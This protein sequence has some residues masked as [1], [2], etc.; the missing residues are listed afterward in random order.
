LVIYASHL[1]EA[2]FENGRV[3]NESVSIMMDAEDHFA[4]EGSYSLQSSHVSI[5]YNLLHT[6]P[7][8]NQV[9]HHDRIGNISVNASCSDELRW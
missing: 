5:V 3:E 9:N 2:A 8:F 4:W 7:K 1:N 6:F